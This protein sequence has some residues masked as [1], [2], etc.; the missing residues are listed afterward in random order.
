MALESIE[1][2]SFESLLRQ[3]VHDQACWEVAHEA[4]RFLRDYALMPETSQG[5]YI[6]ADAFKELF[7]PYAASK[8]GRNVF[9]APVH[10]AAAVLAA[11]QFRRLLRAHDHRRHVLF[12]T[13]IPGAGKT[14]AFAGR[15]LAG[16]RLVYERQLSD[17]AEA[18]KK[19]RETLDA[20]LIPDILVMDCEPERAL[21]NTLAR[22]K[23]EGRAASMN[24]MAQ[25]QA[26]LPDTL[27]N[28]AVRYP[29]RISITAIY[30]NDEHEPELI[31]GDVLSRIKRG[32]IH[33]IESRLV[34]ELAALGRQQK[35]VDAYIRQCHG[36]APNP[37]SIRDAGKYARTSASV[38]RQA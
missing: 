25:I 8:A 31:T 22:F 30:M 24:A 21:R 7:P 9:N 15:D 37:R 34:A 38:A 19:I 16:Y 5:R 13:G 36:H 28:L 27:H 10:N 26:G 23:A 6:S 1:S 14:C 3:E 2:R 35:L 18:D 4:G 33:E 32:T 20:G 17:F 29:G 12:V 11:E